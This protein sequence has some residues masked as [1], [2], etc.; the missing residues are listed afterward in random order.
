MHSLV[1]ACKQK[2]IVGNLWDISA[3]HKM[4]YLL[5]CIL[6]HSGL[7]NAKIWIISKCYNLNHIFNVPLQF[8]KNCTFLKICLLSFVYL[9]LRFYLFLFN[10]YNFQIFFILTRWRLHAKFHIWTVNISLTLVFTSN[11]FLKKNNLILTKRKQDL[12]SFFFYKSSQKS[13][14]MLAGKHQ[15]KQKPQ[16]INWSTQNNAMWQISS[17]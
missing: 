11:F 7:F 15:K 9:Q 12:C 6:T 5:K 14:N 8:F 1:M 3:D 10:T 13:R 4:V 16:E 2:L 17:K